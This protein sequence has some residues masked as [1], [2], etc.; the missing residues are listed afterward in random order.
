MTTRTPSLW[1]SERLT[2]D[3]SITLTVLYA[4]TRMELPPLHACAM[5]LLHEI[6][7][8]GITTQIVVPPLDDRFFVYLFGRGV[9]A[10]KNRFRWCTPQLKVEPMEVAL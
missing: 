8:R 2:L 10:P 4:D 6:E 1:E 3:R 7:R 5:T 9:L